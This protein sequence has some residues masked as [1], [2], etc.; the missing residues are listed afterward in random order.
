MKLRKASMEDAKLLFDWRN[1]PITRAA[2]H[3]TGELVFSEHCAWLEKALL[4]RDIYIA[5]IDGIPVGTVRA[6]AG[7][8]TELSWTVAPHRR[9]KGLGTR[10]VMAALALHSPARA[11]IKADNAASIRIAEKV[12][13]RLTKVE[14]GVMHYVAP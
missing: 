2:S 14:G 8:P 10:I 4:T 5:E 1:D 9:C 7:K 6:D 3:Q 11:E 13:M 12:G